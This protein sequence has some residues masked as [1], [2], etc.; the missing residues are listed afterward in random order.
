LDDLLPDLKA[1]T[2]ATRIESG[3]KI[4]RDLVVGR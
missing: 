1:E 2:P 3:S 4:K